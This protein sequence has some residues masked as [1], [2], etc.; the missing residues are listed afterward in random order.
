MDIRARKEE[1]MAPGTS[2]KGGGSGE[3][4]D[5]QSLK[6]GPPMGSPGRHLKL[7]E[8]LPTLG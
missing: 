1:E 5:P 8:G 4:I 7:Q 6:A 3:G 2:L